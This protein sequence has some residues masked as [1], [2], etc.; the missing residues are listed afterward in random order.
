MNVLKG[1]QLRENMRIGTFDEITK[2]AS[3]RKEKICK[4]LNMAEVIWRIE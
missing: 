1:T 4:A 3:Q 2:N